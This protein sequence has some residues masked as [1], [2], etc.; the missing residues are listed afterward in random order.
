MPTHVALL[1]GINVGGRNRV[2]MEDLRAL[3]TKLGHDDVFTYIQSGN[4]LFTA[5]RLGEATPTIAEA[6]AT[7][8]AAE[9]GVT[10]PVVVLT[11]DDLTEIITANPFSDEPNPKCVHAVVFSSPGG[12]ELLGRVEAAMAKSAALG[13][14]DNA[15]VLGRTLYLHTPDGF[16]RSKLAELLVRS[17]PKGS[18]NGTARNWA[19]MLK[20]KGLFES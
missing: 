19:T 7:S 18:A 10:A 4:V 6:L 16:G 5:A 20:L 9:L 15:R 13:S 11:K 8:I 1:R 3:V 17:A 14:R 12:S 2:L